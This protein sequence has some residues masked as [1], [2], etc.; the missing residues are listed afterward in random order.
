M[1]EARSEYKYNTKGQFEEASLKQEFSAQ[2]AHQKHLGAFKIQIQA[3]LPNYQH[4]RT[5]GSRTRV[6]DF[7]SF[8]R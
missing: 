4:F 1:P 5:S 3:P 6:Q 2:A 8:L 7:F